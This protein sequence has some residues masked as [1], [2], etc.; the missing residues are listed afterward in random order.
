M[1]NLYRQ[2]L[3]NRDK[4]QVI[5]SKLGGKIV[6]KND[7]SIWYYRYMG[8]SHP[9]YGPV[10]TEIK[11]GNSWLVASV[12]PLV[13]LAMDATYIMAGLIWQGDRQRQPSNRMLEPG[14]YLV[15]YKPEGR[16]TDVT[17]LAWLGKT[18]EDAAPR[19]RLE[20]EAYMLGNYTIHMD[21]NGY[22]LRDTEAVSHYE[23]LVNWL[24]EI[25]DTERLAEVNDDPERAMLQ[26]GFINPITYLG[27]DIT[28][29]VLAA[30]SLLAE[31][32]D[33]SF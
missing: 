14:I 28:I 13:F 23:D 3:S 11:L 24:A 25:G 20:V 10:D 12:H 16:I 22:W 18:P 4:V 21:S 32:H 33:Y 17:G 7:G 8:E 27:H 2:H 19:L 15:E 29:A 9:L 31:F 1:T 6:E 30:T 26:C 5:T